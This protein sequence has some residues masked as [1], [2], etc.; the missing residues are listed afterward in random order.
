MTSFI[1]IVNKKLTIS[2]QASTKMDTIA[3][4]YMLLDVQ[5]ITCNTKV[6]CGDGSPDQV[7]TKLP[8]RWTDTWCCDSDV[9]QTAY[10]LQNGDPHDHFE[11]I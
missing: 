11:D 3:M 9:I 10:K 2:L 7:S 5:T 8:L 6:T 1:S 4:A